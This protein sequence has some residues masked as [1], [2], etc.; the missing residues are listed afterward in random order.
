MPPLAP[1]G[2]RLFARIIDI[3]IVLIPAFLLDWASVGLQDSDFTAGRSAV[4]G[5]FT[6]GVGFLYEY[7]MTRSGGQTVGKKAM[8]LRAAMLDNG[9]IPTAQ[10]SAVRAAILWLPAFCCSC[11]WF[12]IIGITVAFDKPYR[13]GVH[14]KASKTVVVEAR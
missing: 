1:S 13:Q 12:V 8:G 7:F 9:S 11:V 2:R 10:A 4:G 3:V 5:V 14:E 6:A